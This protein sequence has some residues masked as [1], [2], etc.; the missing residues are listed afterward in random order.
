MT[1]TGEAVVVVV[2]TA[3]E[4]GRIAGAGDSVDWVV[5]VDDEPDGEAVTV[6]VVEVVAVGVDVDIRGVVEIRSGVVEELDVVGVEELVGDSVTVGS[7]VEIT[8]VPTTPLELGNQY[9]ARSRGSDTQLTTN[10]VANAAW[11][12]A[13]TP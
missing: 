4:V 13:S 10:T 11:D 8:V 9:H 7:I 12:A 1:V 5:D 2:G 6:D 3:D